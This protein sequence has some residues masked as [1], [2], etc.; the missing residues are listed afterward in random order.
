MSSSNSGKPLTRPRSVGHS[1]LRSTI[2]SWTKNR[3]PHGAAPHSSLAFTEVWVNKGTASLLPR[4]A[5]QQS[6]CLLQQCFGVHDRWH[7][8]MNDITRAS[9]SHRTA[10]TCF[11]YLGVVHQLIKWQQLCLSTMDM[12]STKVN[13]TPLNFLLKI[14]LNVCLGALNGKG[15]VSKKII[16]SSPCL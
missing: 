16:Y 14:R 12:D 10:L 5:S 13:K 3:S 15:F 2:S 4:W 8:H 11:L 9:E 6:L 1:L 7:R